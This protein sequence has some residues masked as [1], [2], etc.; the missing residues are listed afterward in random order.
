[1]PY[2]D[3]AVACFF[4]NLVQKFD[5]VHVASFPDVDHILVLYQC[6][7]DLEEGGEVEKLRRYVERFIGLVGISVVFFVLTEPILPFA[8]DV[9]G[10][11]GEV[12][13]LLS[14]VD[15]VVVAGDLVLGYNFHDHI[16]VD[17]VTLVVEYDCNSEEI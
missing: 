1:M 9:T 3:P 15:S 13:F 6:A 17:I 14:K 10:N 11:G 5:G 4:Q 2:H 8:S 7:E 12:G 16:L